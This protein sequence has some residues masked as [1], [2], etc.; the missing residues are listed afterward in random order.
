[1]PVAPHLFISLPTRM[2]PKCFIHFIPEATT[3]K[4]IAPKCLL[5][6]LC[7]LVWSPAANQITL[8]LSYE[9]CFCKQQ[10]LSTG[11]QSTDSKMNEGKNQAIVKKSLMQKTEPHQGA[12]IQEEIFTA[13]SCSE[14]AISIVSNLNGWQLSSSQMIIGLGFLVHHA[15][16]PCPDVKTAVHLTLSSGQDL[17]S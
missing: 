6:F 15:S 12:H 11:R 13:V 2:P 8:I 7:L 16:G 14:F 9:C 17:I 1:M 10:P 3:S 4:T 5:L